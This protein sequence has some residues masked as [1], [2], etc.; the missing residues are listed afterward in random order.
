MMTR[1]IELSPR[2]RLAADLVP[3]GARLADV[4]TD[5]A[6]LPACLLMEGKIPSAI[7]A[8]LRE[9]P[10][11]RAR[12]TAAEYGCGDRMAFRLCDGLSGIQPDEVNT[13]AM[14]G[15]GGETIAAI[16]AAAPWTWER[17]CLL[18]LQPMSAQPFLRRWLQ[19]HGYTIR[20]ELLSREGDTLYTTFEVYA[21]PMAEL[22]PAEL[23]AGRQTRGEGSPLRLAYL[24]RL[25]RQTERA[26]AGLKRSKRPED[27]SRLAELEQVH[28]GLLDMKEEWLSWQR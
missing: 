11:S 28:Q 27:A 15:M 10:L 2:L 26:I 22:T 17:E 7:A 6:Y 19:A 5:H 4:G 14:A 9:G 16:L 3:E 1:R 25:L 23:W 13:I 21:G 24:D 8:D 18:L 12:E 20:R